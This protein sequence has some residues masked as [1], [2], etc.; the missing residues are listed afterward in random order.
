MFSNVCEC[1]PTLH[2]HTHAGSAPLQTKIQLGFRAIIIILSLYFVF[3]FFWFFV[4]CICVG[5][6]GISVEKGSF[7]CCRSNFGLKSFW[8]PLRAWKFWDKKKIYISHNFSMQNM[9][10]RN[11]YFYLFFNITTFRHT[12]SSSKAEYVA[13]QRTS[14]A[15]QGFLSYVEIYI[16]SVLM[17]CKKMHCK[18]W[19]QY[20]FVNFGWQNYNKYAELN[21]TDVFQVNTLSKHS[22]NTTKLVHFS[23]EL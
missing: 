11:L 22:N 6:A 1:L 9:A 18:M 10:K 5:A 13:S 8:H 16:F 17:H 14:K 4:F 7:L 20:S 12:K 2:T 23:S 15:L 3:F 21:S 19:Q